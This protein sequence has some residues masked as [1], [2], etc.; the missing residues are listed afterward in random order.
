MFLSLSEI[1]EEFTLKVWKS[2]PG[3]DTTGSAV[4][5]VWESAVGGRVEGWWQEARATCGRAGGHS[6]GPSAPYPKR[7]AFEGFTQRPPLFLPATPHV[8]RRHRAMA[9]ACAPLARHPWGQ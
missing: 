3:G 8:P 6:G 9:S 2:P 4:P 7:D 1:D 5:G